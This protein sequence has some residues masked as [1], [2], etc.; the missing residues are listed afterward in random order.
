MEKRLQGWTARCLTVG[1]FAAA[2]LFSGPSSSAEEALP[3]LIKRIE[4]SI[5]VVLT[6]DE[7][8]KIKGQG[9]GFFVSETGHVVTNHHVLEGARQAAIKTNDGKVYRVEK[10][11]ADDQEGDLVRLTIDPSGDR[12]QPLPLSPVAPEVGERIFIIGTPLGLEKTVTDG[13]VSAVREI[14][15]FGRIIQLTAPISQGSSGSPVVNMKGEVIGVATFFIIAGQNLNFAIPSERI[16]RL[17]AGEGKTLAEWQGEKT[18]ELRSETAGIYSQGLRHLW[19]EDYAGA[20][21]FFLEAARR[22]PAL[23]DAHF[24]I[25]YCKAKLGRYREALEAYKEAARLKPDDPDTHNNLCVAYNML[26]RYEDALASCARALQ[27]KPDLAEAHNNLC[28]ALHKVGRYEESI[29]SC[30][31]TIR[32]NPGLTSAHFNLGNNYLVL[33][34]YGEAVESYKRAIR[35]DPDYAEAHLNLGASYFG[36]GRYEAAIESYKQAIRLKPGLS[37]AHLDLGMAYLKIGDKGSAFEVFKILK[38]IDQE[39]ANKLFSLIYE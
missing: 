12:I 30:K 10:I 11:V 37:K 35:I 34:F 39:S 29:T 3:A 19:I 21:P 27:K 14:P 18:D 26:E 28:W 17:V 8:G 5:V 23:A 24:Q 22:N 9:T 7:E 15:D 13:I 20:L 4:P 16:S 32:L 25:G 33:K 38:G 6:S 31:E 1:M 2:A 36:M